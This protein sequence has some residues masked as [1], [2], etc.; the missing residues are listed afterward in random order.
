MHSLRSTN[1]ITVGDR[2]D[3][4]DKREREWPFYATLAVAVSI[5]TFAA[6]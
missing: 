3:L 4:L 5:A 1:T 2:K 6:T